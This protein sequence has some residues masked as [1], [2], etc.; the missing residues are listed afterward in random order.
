MSIVAGDLRA[1]SSSPTRPGPTGSSGTGSRRKRSSSIDTVTGCGRSPGS[2]LRGRGRVA[3]SPSPSLWAAW[4]ARSSSR[5]AAA[6]GRGDRRRLSRGARPAR[7][8]A[9]ARWRS[10][11]RPRCAR[12]RRL[13]PGGPRPS[14][15]S[16]AVRAAVRDHLL[17]RLL[18]LGPRFASGERTGE[19]ANTLAGGVEA[20]DAYLAQYLPQ[21]YL[22]ALVPPLVLAAVLWADP[23]SALVL[24]LTFPLIPLFMWL[25]GEAARGADA[26][27]VGDTCPAC[28]RASSTRSRGC[29]RCGPSGAPTTRPGAIAAGERAAPR[30]HDGRAAPRLRLGAG[31]RGA[32]DA[33]DRGG[34]GRGRAAPALRADRRSATALF[35]LVLAPEFYRP[36]RAPRRRVPRG[37]GGDGGGASASP[38]SLD[39]DRAARGARRPR[40]RAPRAPPPPLADARPSARDVRFEDVRF[41]YASRP[42][43]RARRLHPRRPGRRHRGARSARAARARRR[44]PSSSSAS[45]SPIGAR[46]ASTARPSRAI[47]PGRVAPPRGLGAPAAAALPRHP[48]REPAPRAPGRVARRARRRPRL[49][50]PR[51]GVREL[52]RGLGDAGGRGRRAALRRR[53]P[54]GRPRP[55]LPEGR[56]A[57]SSSTSPPPSSTPRARPRSW[58]RSTSLR[59]GRTVLLIAHRLATVARADRV[60]LLARGR[61]VEEGPPARARPR[62]ARATRGSSR[63]WE[64]ARVTGRL[65]ASSALAAPRSAAGRALAAVRCRSSPWPP[66]SG[67]WAPPRGC[68]R[69]QRCTR[70]SPRSPGGDRRRARLRD[71]ARRRCATSSGWPRTT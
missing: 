2:S 7:R 33:R 53:G 17:R 58:R 32:R 61:V 43:A 36:L 18:A 59:R 15:H 37:D 44:R 4:P 41:A 26:P 12:P 31:A 45:S 66:G 52:P 56:A 48:A 50:P 23:L 67:S 14:A 40:C 13:G 60:A 55:R 9:A 29:R 39:A 24:L 3:A 70:R 27:A 35:V 62:R 19:L 28:P 54:A 6:A 10:P 71:R 57:S 5:Q 51:R 42:R 11:A 69:G 25:I 16:G 8:R 65:A 68:S 47:G 34:R 22:A 46:S 63:P 64:G 38:R 30:G 49:G 1:R 21:A 20:L